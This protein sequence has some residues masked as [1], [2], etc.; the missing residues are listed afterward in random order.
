MNPTEY[1][2]CGIALLAV[3]WLYGISIGRPR[4]SRRTW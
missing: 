2:C 3:A 4:P 1:L